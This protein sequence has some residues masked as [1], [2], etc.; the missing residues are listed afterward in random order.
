MGS[1]SALRQ[2]R[3]EMKKQTLTMMAML[4]LMVGTGVSNASA[5]EKPIDM[6]WALRSP[7]QMPEEDSN[8]ALNVG[9]VYYRLMALARQMGCEAPRITTL[10][11]TP[12]M[13]VD[14]Q[15]R[16]RDALAAYKEE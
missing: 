5:Q 11:P 8:P 1:E 6:S 13:L 3:N 9:V 14:M 16:L 10:A 12:E 2:R 4:G 7:A 15:K